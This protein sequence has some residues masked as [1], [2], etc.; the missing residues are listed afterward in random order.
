MVRPEFARAIPSRTFGGSAGA[1]RAAP[2]AARVRA[3]DNP[4]M[5]L[6]FTKM[7]GLG[8]DYVY[9]NTFD[10]ELTNPVALARRMSDRHTGVGSDGLILIARPDAPAAAAGAHVRMIMYNADGSRSEMCGN[11]VRCVAKYA[12][13]RGLARNNPMLVQTDRGILTLALTIGD[14]QRVERVRVD[15]G[16]P[17]LEPARIPVALG[18]DRVVAT[19]IP[20]MDRTLEMTCVSM[21]NPHA[22]FFVDDV[23]RVP[24][25]DWGEKLERHPLFPQRTNVHFVQV[26][27][28][29]RVRMITWERG[30]GPTQACGTGAAAVCVAGVLTRRTQRT[31]RAALPGGELELAWDETTNH[32]FK[33]GPATEVF[34]GTWLQS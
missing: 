32:V 4:D 22:V 20:L 16:E 27:E 3:L 23:K 21:G 1:C 10:R 25:R 26:V 14:D 17:I 33:T 31:I 34:D 28:P 30:T 18:G 5:A 19:A 29:T 7:H 8:N 24:L 9:I 11:G 2:V 6:T 12:W 13:D 15:M